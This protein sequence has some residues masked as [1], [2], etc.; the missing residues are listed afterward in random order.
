MGDEIGAGEPSV[1]G[2]IPPRPLQGPPNLIPT[3]HYSHCWM[4]KKIRAQP[5][6]GR[7]PRARYLFWAFLKVHVIGV[8]TSN[9]E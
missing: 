6:Q 8:S 2:Q 4:L 5:Y 3:W 7:L 1:F 9:T